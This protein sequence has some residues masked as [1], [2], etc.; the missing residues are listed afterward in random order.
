MNKKDLFLSAMAIS[1]GVCIGKAIGGVATSFINIITDETV[2]D[3][4]EKA[5]RKI[6]HK[7]N[8]DSETEE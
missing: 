5:K 6:H 8:K 3:I 4:T 7:L 2:Y 1:F